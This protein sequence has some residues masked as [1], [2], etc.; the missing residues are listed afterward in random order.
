MISC[1]VQVPCPEVL[2]LA[3]LVRSVS[4]IKL[5]TELPLHILQALAAPSL[6]GS[7]SAGICRCFI[8]GHNNDLG[9]A[10]FSVPY[11]LASGA[12]TVC[13]GRGK[14]FNFQASSLKFHILWGPLLAKP[15][16]ASTSSKRS[17]LFIT[18]RTFCLLQKASQAS[19]SQE[20]HFLRKK[21]HPFSVTCQVIG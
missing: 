4:G 7:F 18:R 17:K 15:R 11:M 16:I 21:C 9:P 5:L 10:L 13:S 12:F 6:K 19:I 3:L 20:Q 2:P 1:W 14:D 8:S